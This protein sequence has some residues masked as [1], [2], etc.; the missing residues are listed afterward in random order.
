MK[1]YILFLFIS[2]LSVAA[3]IPGLATYKNDRTMGK[4]LQLF[5]TLALGTHYVL[6]N[7]YANRI[8]DGELGAKPPPKA[9]P[10]AGCAVM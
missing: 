1:K 5:G 8:A 9:L 4:A 7:I 6:Q 2:F 3:Y 10:I